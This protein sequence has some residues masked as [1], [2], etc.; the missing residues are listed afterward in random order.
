MNRPKPPCGHQFRIEANDSA[1]TFAWKHRPNDP[2][3]FFFGV[4]YLVSS[5]ML[6]YLIYIDIK[7]AIDSYQRSNDMLRIWGAIVFM[8]FFPLIF[9]LAYLFLKKNRLEK[10]AF[11]EQKLIFQE[12]KGPISFVNFHWMGKKRHN[13]NPISFVFSK[14]KSYSF[15]RSDVDRIVLEG[16][17]QQQRLR[18]DDGAIRVEIGEYLREPEREWLF[19]QIQQWKSAGNKLT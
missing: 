17:G 10:I 8:M 4:Y 1:T 2:I 19:E 7:Q 16:F 13:F 6:S 9:L 5:F 3:R 11:K 15:N 18:F 12:G 14:V